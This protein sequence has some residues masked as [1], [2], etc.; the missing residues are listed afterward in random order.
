MFVRIGRLVIVALASL[1]LAGAATAAPRKH[2]QAPKGPPNALQGFSQNRDQPVRIQAAKLEVHDK[3]QVATF[4]GDVRVRQGDTNMR[5]RSL[6][7]FYERDKDKA[8][9]GKDGDKAKTIQAATPGP[10]GQQKIRRL[11]AIGNVVVTQKG[12]T[13]SGNLGIF[14][15]RSN[16]V[17]LTGKVVL[18]EGKNVLRGDKLVVNLTSGV[19]RI[20]SARNGHGR[21]EGLFVPSGNG[22]SGKN[23]LGPLH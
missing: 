13:A 23:P 4:S 21:V 9:N 17:T 16:T 2:K 5:C 14:D 12:Q 6:K 19:S 11:E 8:K 3:Q 1:A 7:V 20:E 10:G 22:P 18:T 15:M